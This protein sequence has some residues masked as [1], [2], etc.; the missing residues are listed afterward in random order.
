MRPNFNKSFVLSITL[1]FCGSALA[2]ERI[3]SYHSD[4]TVRQDASLMVAE[5]IRVRAEGVNIRRGIYRDFP[6]SYKDRQGNRYRVEFQIIEVKRNGSPEPYF[7]ENLSNGV[8]VYI[9]NSQTNLTHGE[10]EYRLL[11]RTTRQLGFFADFDELYWNVTGNGWMFS[12]DQAS[13]RIEL[14]ADIAW[15]S[16]RSDFYTGLKSERGK[17]A[18]FKI[19]SSRVVEFKTTEALQPRQ[20]LTVALGWPKGIVHEPTFTERVEFFLK[21]N[22]SALVLLIGLILP[23]G[24]YL[25]SWHNYGRDPVRGIIIPRFEPPRNLSAAAC[26]YISD[27]GLNSKAFTAAIVSL[28][29]KGYLKIDEQDKDYS[30]Y[31]EKGP[32][33]DTASAGEAAVLQELLPETDSW[34]ELDD[35]NYRE[36]LSARKALKKALKAEHH[37]RLFK[38]NTIY[39][40]PAAVISILA[41]AFAIS[42]EGGPLPWVIFIILTITMHIVFLFLLRAPT[43]AGRLVMDEVEGLKLYLNT[44]EQFRLD[45]MRSPELTPEVF[46]IFLP[47]AFALGVENNWCER[48]AR[49]FPKE[50]AQGGRYSNSWYS[51]DRSGLNGLHHI[52]SNL[53]SSL[54]SA[55]SSA[56]SPPGSSSGSGGGGSSGGGGGGGGGGGW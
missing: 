38:L 30:L 50:I 44:A 21:D 14:P 26:R 22:G 56:S 13:A 33:H 25:R 41:V 1:F 52:G 24:W 3:L 23:F 46:E 51:G 28:G 48:F 32:K 34:I 45:R 18:E 54:S 19:I 29:V 17:A 12:I 2:Q 55:I 6:T 40:L 5:N 47:Y 42:R 43:P 37:G 31:R 36:F 49:E 11:Y 39:M 16:L 20:G 9:G 27:M 7:T 10:H 4:I 8:R 15:D 35:K 53:N